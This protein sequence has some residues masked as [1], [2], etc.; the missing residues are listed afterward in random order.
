[1]CMDVRIFVILVICSFRYHIL[2]GKYGVADLQ[3]LSSPHMLA[4]SLQE[5]FLHLDKADGVRMPSPG[6]LEPDTSTRVV[7]SEVFGMETFGYVHRE[8]R[9]LCEHHHAHIKKNR[10]KTENN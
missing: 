7:L 10:K 1:M 3:T 2:L 4:T 5:N 9:S 8:N 6:C